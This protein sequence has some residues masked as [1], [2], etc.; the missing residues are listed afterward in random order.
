MWDP[1][2]T[3]R[4]ESSA[5]MQPL[6]QATLALFVLANTLIEVETVV[7][8]V[9]SVIRPIGCKI[10]PFDAS[11]ATAVCSATSEYL[12]GEKAAEGEAGA[13]AALTRLLL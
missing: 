9:V 3:H 1:G 5:D 13:A 10:M 2:A 4:A 11:L 7:L 6:T 8:F 12:E